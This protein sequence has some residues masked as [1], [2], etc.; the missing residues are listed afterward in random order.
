M[1]QN[2]GNNKLYETLV[3]GIHEFLLKKGFMNT[4]DVF[5]HEL[6]ASRSNTNQSEC[7]P[8]LTKALEIGDP[9]NF[10]RLWNRFLPSTALKSGEGQK[11]DFYAHVFFSIFPLHP[12]N[13][14]QN[15]GTEDAEY[16][17]RME[18]FK[19]F[20]NTKGAELSKTEEFLHFYALPYIPSPTTHPSFKVLFTRAWVNELKERI[21][22]FFQGNSP[23]NQQPL[24]VKMAKAYN[25]KAPKNDFDESEQ[26]EV[27]IQNLELQVRELQKEY[28]IL[29]QRE[30]QAKSTLLESQTKWTNF[31]K[32]ILNMAK[33]LYKTIEAIS[34]GNDI[35]PSQLQA[36]FEKIVRYDNFLN[37]S[38]DEISGASFT[39][40]QADRTQTDFS[41]SQFKR[42]VSESSLSYIRPDKN[43]V[44]GYSALPPLNFAIV[45]RDLSN[46]QDDLQICA[47]LQALRWRLTR[48]QSYLRKETLAAYIKYNILCTTKPHDIL[49]DKL[50]TWNRRVIEYTV[51][52]LNVVAS[53]C[54]G[55]TYLLTKENIIQ[56][57]SSI[58]YEELEDSI[59]RQNA[60]GSLQKLSLR[61]QAQSTMIE[62][63]MIDWLGRLLKFEAENISFYSLEYATALLMNL[64]LRTAGKNKI[65]NS[66][67]DMLSILNG[68]LEHENTQV[69]TYVNG[70]LY[71][72]LTRQKLKERALKLG[73]DKT[74]EYLMKNSDEHFKRQIQYILDQLFSEHED[75]CLSDENDDDIEDRDEDESEMDDYIAEDE[76]MD[77]IINEGI[78]T[79]EE[80]LNER[81]GS[82]ANP[83]KES[84]PDK[85]LSRP[86]TP[87][88]VPEKPPSEMQSKP[89][90]PRTPAEQEQEPPPPP[91]QETNTQG[92]GE[93]TY[94]F[95]SRDRIPRSPL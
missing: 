59:L 26:Y 20:L 67:L 1:R 29:Q 75:D 65:E 74:L 84:S 81:Y 17:R 3:Q 93:F 53:E 21:S 94:A 46:L 9:D 12:L 68:L 7:L 25:G 82:K 69:R 5:Q 56:S 37:M 95:K 60:L 32:D 85:P 54:A 83:S 78:L 50:L 19:E 66:Q 13:R 15:K 64:S 49:L 91:Q 86:V 57:L 61:R 22:K 6:Q 47:L 35:D 16:K 10:F 30:E 31:S 89:K 71:S 79:G 18:D 33:E 77:D 76:D 80:L 72:I 11:L 55:R 28:S 24:L 44:K 34:R 40:S 87:A 45:I 8:Q 14:S 43:M 90:I 27:Q 39:Y 51:R 58:L 52:F 42:D 36:I 2:K 41:P 92:T 48:S 4:L 70:T 63:E 73:T 38:N 88:R 62:L 23:S